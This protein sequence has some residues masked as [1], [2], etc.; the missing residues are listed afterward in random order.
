[1][2]F[3]N[4]GMI[5]MTCAL[6]GCPGEKND[7]EGGTDP[8]ATGGESASTSDGATGPTTSGSTATS[9]GE[10]TEPGATSTSDGDATGPGETS[11]STGEPGPTTCEKYCALLVACIGLTPE[12][13]AT[14]P[15]DC[16]A[17]LVELDGECRVAVVATYECHAELTCAQLDDL[18]Q[19]KVGPCTDEGKAQ[20]EVCGF[21]DSCE[22][23]GGGDGS[24]NC[25]Y[26]RKCAGE[27]EM[28]MRCTEAA[29]EC[30]EAGVKFGE[31]APEQ[32]CSDIAGLEAK[33]LSCCG[34]GA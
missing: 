25:E 23:T 28:M 20:E 13:A 6:A 2:Q 11:T 4:F 34:I 18:E 12:E 29:C 30:L 7:T 22:L 10:A 33:A 19:G 16:E 1:M 17:E 21:G 5:L 27:P 8:T 32:V 9:T 15:Q 3:H 24:E 14:C 31:C 26:T